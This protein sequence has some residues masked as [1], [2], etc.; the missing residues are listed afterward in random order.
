M[1]WCFTWNNPDHGVTPPSLREFYHEHC[2]YLVYGDEVAPKTGTPHYQGFFTLKKKKSLTALKKLGMT[3]HLE[4]ANGTS[5][6]ASDYC[7]K[8]KEFVE[9]GDQS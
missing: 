5:I 7:K 1:R 6:Q 9:Y 3:C 2:N 8:D 4:A